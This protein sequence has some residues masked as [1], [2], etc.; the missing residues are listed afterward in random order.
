[1]RSANCSNTLG[2]AGGLTA[3][4]HD[5]KTVLWPAMLRMCLI[6]LFPTKVGVSIEPLHGHRTEQYDGRRV[7]PPGERSPG[8]IDAAAALIYGWW[9]SDAGLPPLTRLPVEPAGNHASP[10]LQHP[11]PTS[12]GPYAGA[13]EGATDA[14]SKFTSE[15]PFVLNDQHCIIDAAL[16]G[17][18]VGDRDG[19]HGGAVYR[20]WTLHSGIGRMEA[21]RSGYH[22][23]YPNRRPPSPE[24]AALLAELRATL[25]YKQ[26][27]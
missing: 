24:F 17:G 10:L 8:M 23:Y 15:G 5:V 1:M 4:R 16:H 26:G 2:I 6:P 12:G 19:R 27:E 14:A 11:L 13:F 3:G 25:I 7:F 21:R 18:G 20:R 22:L 9:W